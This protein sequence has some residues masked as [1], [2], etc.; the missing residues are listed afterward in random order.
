MLNICVIGCGD[1]GTQHAKAWKSRPD[2]RVV[3]VA[4]PIE[5][6]RNKLAE[7]VIAKAYAKN[8]DAINHSGVD[9]VSVCIPNTFH[10]EVTCLAARAG[11][12]VLSEKPIA[13][14]LEQAD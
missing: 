5:E 6:R 13:L 7:L 1:L 3:S 10:S 14:T 8:E 12:H 11:K 2:C 4:D 9:I